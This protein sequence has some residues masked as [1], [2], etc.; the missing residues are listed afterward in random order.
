MA[1]IEILVMSSDGERKCLL[2]RDEMPE[3]SSKA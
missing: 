2:K 3:V 1:R